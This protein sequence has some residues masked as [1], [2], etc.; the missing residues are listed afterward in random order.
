VGEF[1][2]GNSNG[3]GIYTDINGDKYVG[4]FKDGKYVG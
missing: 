3:Y 2:N 1:K 4:Y